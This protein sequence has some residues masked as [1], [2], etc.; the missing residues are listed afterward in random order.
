M[1]WDFKKILTS[2]NKKKQKKK[3]VNIITIKIYW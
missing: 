1:G 2:K 3:T